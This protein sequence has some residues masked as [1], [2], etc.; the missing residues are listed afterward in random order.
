VGKARFRGISFSFCNTATAPRA[1][2]RILR[3]ILATSVGMVDEA[4]SI[5]SRELTEDR[6]YSV[7]YVDRLQ[8]QY[9]GG[10]PWVC[11]LSV[12]TFTKKSIGEGPPRDLRFSAPRQLFAERST[13]VHHTCIVD[14]DIFVMDGYRS[15]CHGSSR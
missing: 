1:S 6:S 7:L 11:E 2:A 13:E 14:L 4:E 9:T 10:R 5:S 8:L 12:L 3:A 15:T